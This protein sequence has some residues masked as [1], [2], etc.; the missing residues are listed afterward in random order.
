MDKENEIIVKKLNN[1]LNSINKGDK[2]AF[3]KVQ[4]IFERLV[5]TSAK[6]FYADVIYKDLYA[7]EDF[8][9]EIWL[10]LWIRLTKDNNPVVIT[11]IA[12]LKTLVVLS[13]QTVIESINKM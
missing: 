3:E 2:K 1:I 13:T 9:Q 7:L 12:D 4:D 10:T 8:K 6:S 5:K 11:K